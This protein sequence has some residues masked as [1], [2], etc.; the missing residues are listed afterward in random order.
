MDNNQFNADNNQF[1]AGN[2]QMK[3]IFQWAGLGCS[4]FGWFLTVIFSIITCARGGAVLE[5]R[6]KFGISLWVIGAI[7]GAII[8]VVGLILSVLSIEK[9]TKINK[10]VI[11]SVIVAVLTVLWVLIPNTTLCSYSCM[12]N[13]KLNLK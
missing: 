6:E 13:D 5:G 4:C 8:A 9:G 7:L 11:V 3:K 10:F 12:L 1:G 2:N